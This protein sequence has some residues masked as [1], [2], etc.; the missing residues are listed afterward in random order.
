[1]RTYTPI[2]LT[3]IK[4]TSAA[5]FPG[6]GPLKK[7]PQLKPSSSVEDMGLVVLL[8]LGVMLRVAVL[9]P[10]GVIVPLPLPLPEGL[11]GAS[12]TLG[13]VSV[14]D[15]AACTAISL[16]LQILLLLLLLSG[17]ATRPTRLG[18]RA[19]QTF[20]REL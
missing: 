4:P 11:G 10:V 15:S 18:A 12:G 5:S 3:T 19:L 13:C 9:L 14:S 1:M 2:R 16:L 6:K 20:K 8:L 17:H 7:D